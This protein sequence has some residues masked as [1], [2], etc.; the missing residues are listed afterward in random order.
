MN[1]Y[2]IFGGVAA[3]IGGIIFALT[4]KKKKTN[5]TPAQQPPVNIPVSAP[6]WP[7]RRPIGAI[8]LASAPDDLRSVE[9]GNRQWKLQGKMQFSKEALFAHAQ[10][11]IKNCKSVNAQGVVIWD[12][13]GQ[14]YFHPVSYMGAPD[15]LSRLAPEMDLYADEFFK[16]F[17]DSGLKVGVCVR[18][19]ELRYYGDPK[20]HYWHHVTNP[21]ESLVRK[22]SYARN[23]WGCT[24]FYVDSNVYDDASLMN[25][26]V[27][28]KVARQFPDCLIMP[29]WEGGL[30]KYWQYTAP[31]KQL[32]QYRLTVAPN[33]RDVVYNAFMVLNIGDSN[34]D[35]TPAVK[36]GN[37]LMFRAWYDAPEIN[38]IRQAYE[39]H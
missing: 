25:P 31:F 23:R 14:E 2:A 1:E 16:L 29:E 33:V 38:L 24:L 15:E 11:S 27:F 30:H 32:Y 35:L 18:P 39:N 21:V 19:D 6:E 13:E 9:L 3:V 20:N 7:D 28:I 10:T 17:T 12:I 26:D 4:R 37:I 22:I 34:M 36:D 8:M 5:S